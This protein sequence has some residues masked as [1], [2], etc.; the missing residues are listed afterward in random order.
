MGSGAGVLRRNMGPHVS[1]EW[2]VR[3]PFIRGIH[4]FTVTY[5][6]TRIP[7]IGFETL[8]PETSS[9]DD[10]DYNYDYDVSDIEHWL[11]SDGHDVD[12]A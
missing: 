2:L 12:M 1:R 7:P 8:E 6:R 10:Y 11:A 9:D 5:V 4:V 3:L